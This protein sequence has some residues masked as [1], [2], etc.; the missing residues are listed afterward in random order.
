MTSKERRLGVVAVILQAPELA[1][2]DFN[3]ILFQFSGLIVGRMGIPYKERNL[4][5][6]SL[7]VDGTN[8]EIGSLTGKIGQLPGVSVK[9]VFTKI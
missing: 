9:T 7:I 3:N 6:V 5:V 1:V 2:S 8:E 4:S